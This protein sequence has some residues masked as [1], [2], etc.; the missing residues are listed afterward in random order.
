MFIKFITLFVLISA[1]RADLKSDYKKSM[2]F[3]PYAT[4]AKAIVGAIGLKVAAGEYADFFH[5]YQAQKRLEIVENTLTYEAKLERISELR[6]EFAKGP[7]ILK[8]NNQ[9][10]Y[11][12][13]ERF[14]KQLFWNSLDLHVN[15]ELTISDFEIYRDYLLN[16]KV[17][18]EGSSKLSIEKMRMISDIID[19]S[20]IKFN[21]QEF[22]LAYNKE[23]KKK[24]VELQ[25]LIKMR[26]LDP[27]QKAK[28]IFNA[29]TVLEDQLKKPIRISGRV[30][31]AITGLMLLGLT[32]TDLVLY[33]DELGDK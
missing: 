23:A 7:F 22:P 31:P 12:Q 8:T 25:S 16:G 3:G 11:L 6:K 13:D 20:I 18:V 27:A 21:N 9:L 10:A 32:I 17:F 15:S 1:S 2:L 4:A 33:F 19:R 14:F 28:E 24:I 26:D 29:Q 5:I 30:M